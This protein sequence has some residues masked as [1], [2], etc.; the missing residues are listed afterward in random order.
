MQATI[1]EFKE[2]LKEICWSEN[3]DKYIQKIKDEGEGSP[4]G[5]ES[6]Y[7]VYIYTNDYQYHINAVERSKDDGYLGC[8]VS[9]RKP[10]PGEQW[11]RGNDLPDGKLCR[12]TWDNI[13]KAI[14]RYELVELFSP[15]RAVCVIP[16]DSEALEEL[17]RCPI[18]EG[19]DSCGPCEG[20]SPKVS[21]E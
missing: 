1:F 13:K 18:V 9:C 14:I 4:E 12:E 3:I 8:T 21:K 6:R 11:T 17:K 7:E 2:W 15:S 20:C 10:R 16:S 19:P 5:M